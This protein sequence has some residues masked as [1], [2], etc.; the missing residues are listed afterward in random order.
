MGSCISTASDADASRMH[1]AAESQLKRTK[2]QMRK[3]TKI[4]L[5]GSGDSGKTT[6]MKQMRLITDGSFSRHELESYRQLVFANLITGMKAIVESLPEI[7]LSIED[8]EEAF[9][10]FTMVEHAADIKEGQPFPVEY[11]EPFRTLW[12]HPM[13]R[14][15]LPHCHKFA[16][17]DNIHYFYASLDRLFQPNYFPTNQDVIQTRAR[18]VGI[19]ETVFRIPEGGLS[20]SRHVSLPQPQGDAPKTSVTSD[21]SSG[22]DIP[23]RLNSSTSE[24]SSI[25]EERWEK[26]NKRV[27]VKTKSRGDGTG[28]DSGLTELRFV[29][30]GQSYLLIHLSLLLMTPVISIGGQRSERRKWIHCFQDVTA[31]MFLVPLSGYDQCIIEE[32]SM[33]QMS[34]AMTIWEGICTMEWFKDTSLILFL[35]KEDLFATKLATAPIHRYF[36]DYEGDPKGDVEAGKEYFKRRFL[37]IAQ[38][39]NLQLQ[40]HFQQ[41]LHMQ[42]QLTINNSSSHSRYLAD[43]A[44]R[45]LLRQV[46]P[47]FITAVNTMAV[48]AVMVSVADMVIRNHLRTALLL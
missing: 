28:N 48:Q 41:Q 46:Y 15:A 20:V 27:T 16:I 45:P 35:N 5:L 14:R 10:A 4:L 9:A 25:A 34:D 43:Q 24:A 31:V 40:Q 19:I 22:M 26:E 18:T 30:V 44:S 13:I 38:K 11:L 8:D 7:G 39:G 47:H 29:D 33:N 1:T 32:R 36:P 42:Q 3:Q 6:I 12:H 23:G 21:V 2:R 17:P 37:R